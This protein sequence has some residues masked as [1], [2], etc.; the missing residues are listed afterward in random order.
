M[1]RGYA[2]VI[3]NLRGTGGSEGTFEFFDEQERSDLYDIV[4]WVAAQPWCD[5]NVGMIGVSYFAMAQLT[6][7]PA[8][9][10]PQGDL[11]LRRDRRPYGAAVHHGLLTRRASS[12]R[13]SRCSA[14]WPERRRLLAR[15]VHRDGA[16]RILN[17][18][19]LHAN[20]RRSTVKPPGWLRAS[21]RVAD[22]AASRPGRPVLPC[23]HAEAVPI[24]EPVRYRVPLIPNARRFA[25]GHRIQ[26]HLA[27][28]DQPSEEPAIMGFRWSWATS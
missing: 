14:S 17:R 9:P 5:G 25:A 10:A 27:S 24:G 8:T 1:P 18:P 2:H 4:E 12:P 7:R 11:P 23:R 20:S 21:L 13:S 19:R 15:Q 16:R 28:D 3:V 26:L 22:E 6:R